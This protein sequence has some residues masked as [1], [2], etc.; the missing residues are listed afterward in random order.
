MYQPGNGNILA[1]ALSRSKRVELDAV[2]SITAEGDQAAE[3][4]VMTR[5]A[6]EATK[7][8]NN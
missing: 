3:I 2:N 6:I 4:L 8:V 1:D 7:E 5:S